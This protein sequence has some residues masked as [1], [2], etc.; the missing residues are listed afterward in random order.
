MPSAIKHV[1]IAS[2]GVPYNLLTEEV[3]T[4]TWFTDVSVCYAG[5]TLKWTAAA[6]QFLSRTTL[7]DTAEGK[8]TQ[9]AELWKVHMVLQ[10]V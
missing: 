2:W 3:N 8:S 7:K 10:V 9:W 1:P 6:L 4:R 5:P